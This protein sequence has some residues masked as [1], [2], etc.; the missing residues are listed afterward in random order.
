M[1]SGVSIEF[2]VPGFGNLDVSCKGDSESIFFVDFVDIFKDFDDL[3]I[4]Y[5]SFYDF[6]ENLRYFDDL[7]DGGVDWDFFLFISVDNLKFSFDVVDS[8]GVFL[9]FINSDSLLFDGWD[10]PDFGVS[11]GDLDDLFDFDWDLFNDFLDN[12]Y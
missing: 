3:R 7:L 2:S 10:F 8:V 4:D 12:W 9:E 6:L 5:D 11:G 1:F